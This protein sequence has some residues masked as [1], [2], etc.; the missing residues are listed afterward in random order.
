VSA[1]PTGE[2]IAGLVYGTIIV[3][4]VIASSS[5]FTDGGALRIAVLVWATTVVLWLAH[6][7]A[8]ALQV[9]ISRGQRLTPAGVG[10][11]AVHQAS[12]LGAAA[13]PTAALLLGGFELVADR[14]AVWL[15]L[16]AGTAA[17]AGQALAYARI[18][19]LSPLATAAI[20]TVN[21]ALGLT[22]VALKAGVS[23]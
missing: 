12:I 17:L 8:Q 3:M 4:A 16:A 22:I 20:V 1:R 6:V 10:E 11:V 21:L 19:K 13:L 23:H 9:S 14:T 5:S 18:E 15:A 2:R 7:Y